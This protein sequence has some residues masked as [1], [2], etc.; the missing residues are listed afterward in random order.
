MDIWEV[1]VLRRKYIS[2]ILSIIVFISFIPGRSFGNGIARN[3]DV[4]VNDFKLSVDNKYF[5][6][7]EVYLYDGDVFVPMKDLGSSLGL[8]ID[9]SM[10]TRRLDISTN[11][12]LSFG[13]WTKYPIAY[14]RG[15]EINAKLR[16]M[17]SINN[18]IRD[19]LN[20]SKTKSS[21]TRPDMKTINVGF[22]GI[23]I[24]IDGENI[25]GLNEAFIYGNDVYLP[26][27]FLS[28]F[29]YITPKWKDDRNIDIDGNG[30]LLPKENGY[31]GT[32]TIDELVD[33]REDLNTRY[34]RELEELNKKKNIIMNVQ[35]PY[36]EVKS[37]TS[38]EA[39][40]NKYLGTLGG[41]KL[42]IGLN[43][44]TGSSY[45]V[46][47]DFNSRYNSAWYDL[48]RRDVEA[49]IWNVYVAISSLYDEEASIQ[50]RIKKFVTFD[51]KGKNLVFSFV[52]SGL[53]MG[54]RVDPTYIKDL[55]DKDLPRL[56]RV[57]FDYETR[58]SGFDLELLISP[59][60]SDF[61]DKWTPLDKLDY[62]ERIN[63]IIKG[64]YPGL[65]IGGSI[66]YSGYEDIDFIIENNK[67]RSSKVLR[68]TG[69]YLKENFGILAS[70]GTS[71]GMD[72]GL[73]QIDKDNLKLVA[74]LDFD[75]SNDKWTSQSRADL[76]NLVHQAIKYIV[77]MWDTNI[78]VEVYDKDSRSIYEY[79]I[80]QDSVQMVMASVPSGNIMEGTSIVLT[81]E[82]PGAKIY[83]SLDKSMPGENSILYEKPI[84]ISKDTTIR[85]IGIKEGLKDSPISTFDYG[86]SA[87]GDMAGGLDGLS[88]SQGSLTPKFS[89]NES[90]YSLSLPFGTTSLSI[91]P[92]ASMGH[93]KINAN[94]VNSGSSVNVNVSHNMTISL[95]HSEDGKAKDRTY[96]IVVKIE[97]EIVSSVKLDDYSFS[98]LQGIQYFS[99]KVKGAYEGHSI[100]ILS[101]TLVGYEK[102]NLGTDGSFMITTFPVD[103]GNRIIGYIYRVYDPSGNVV[104]SG[105][106]SQR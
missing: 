75:T 62:L 21:K 103:V 33:F 27:T 24:F 95:V 84:V 98:T 105:S 104:D 35:I 59:D 48:T 94:S 72:Y 82:T 8:G 73:N 41:V 52:N 1:F 31:Y 55:L 42:S 67:V 10:A 66:K 9:F 14:Q 81:T 36:E 4:V 50:G 57:S 93:I 43:G 92:I 20:N 83:Y 39:Y 64:V 37:L 78:F 40:L 80:S 79:V 60:S 77:G 26:L 74:Y 28:P 22:S 30:I 3:I 69:A 91:T 100:Q 6:H 11:G 12:K 61:M 25:Q 99:G 85:A 29:L 2:F 19:F 45:F 102:V 87:D 86:V 32:Y 44:G 7:K 68:D 71:Y 49:H 5:P 63:N 90:N 65:K 70:Q 23:S 53:D 46:D 18:E 16:I 96:N 17:D 47:I 34:G 15:Y 89:K 51:T 56:N 76:A 38:M 13:D 106:L 97:D 58:L 101:T 54:T 88:L